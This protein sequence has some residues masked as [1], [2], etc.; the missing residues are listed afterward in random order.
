MRKEYDD[1]NEHEFMDSSEVF[2][3]WPKGR[4]VI[5]DS[6]QKVTILV[7]REDHLEIRFKMEDVDFTIFL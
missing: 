2:E 7:N 6:N 1:D 3:D 4:A 5:S